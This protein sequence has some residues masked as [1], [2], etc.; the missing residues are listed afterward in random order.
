MRRRYIGILFLLFF[1]PALTGFCQSVSSIKKDKAKIEKEIA[2]LNKLLEEAK[3]EWAT[4]LEVSE[5]IMELSQAGESARAGELMAGQAEEYYKS[6]NEA[7][8]AMVTLD[9]LLAARTNRW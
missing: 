7:M 4:Y 5:Q 6:F 2:Y 9:L 3:K 8:A 1:L